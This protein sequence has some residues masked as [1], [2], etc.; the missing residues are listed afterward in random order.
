LRL[1]LTLSSTQTRQRSG[2]HSANCR[3]VVAITNAEVAGDEES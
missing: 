2:K 3:Q 1:S